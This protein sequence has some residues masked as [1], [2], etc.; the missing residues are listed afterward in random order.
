[1]L[2]QLGDDD[3]EAALGA[4]Q[5]GADGGFARRFRHQSDAGSAAESTGT[6]GSPW[7]VTI[8]GPALRTITSVPQ[9]SHR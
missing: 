4:A 5:P 2:T 3:F 8:R 7:Q 6:I 9:C 1:M